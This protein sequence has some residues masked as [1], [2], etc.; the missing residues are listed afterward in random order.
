MTN[1][2]G[3]ISA[4]EWRTVPCVVGRPATEDDVLAGRAV[5]Y[6]QGHSDSEQF[7]LPCCGF[8]LLED[9]SEEP[10]VV[11]QSERTPHGVILG[12]RPLTGGNSVCMATEVRLLPLG[13]ES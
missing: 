9:G 13:F 11:V 10:I 7:S 12:V 5:F 2:W 6:V 3:P 8:Q 1:L 4:N